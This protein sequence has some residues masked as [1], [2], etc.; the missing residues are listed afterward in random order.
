MDFISIK[1]LLECKE[2]PKS[3]CDLVY[4]NDILCVSTNSI[5]TYKLLKGGDGHGLGYYAEFSG[6][7][8]CYGFPRGERNGYGK[9]S[10]LRGSPFTWKWF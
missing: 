4:C 1:K 7:G 2:S 3:Q 5:N 10:A 9:I 8:K 6:N